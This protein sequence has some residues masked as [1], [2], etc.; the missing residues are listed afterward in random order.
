MSSRHD[1]R[2]VRTLPSRHH[3]DD[4]GTALAGVC[5]DDGM[6]NLTRIY[7]RTGDEGTTALGDFS[8][9]SKTDSRL[10]AVSYTHLT[11][12]TILLV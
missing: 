12:P 11:L 3:P 8:R 10:Q 1:Q 9:T 7:T 4:P 2:Q 6:V 5:D